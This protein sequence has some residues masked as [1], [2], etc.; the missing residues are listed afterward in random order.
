MVY[1]SAKQR[2]VYSSTLPGLIDCISVMVC[3]YCQWS[4]TQ[5]VLFEVLRTQ[6][7]GTLREKLLAMHYSNVRYARCGQA[8]LSCG[9][10]KI[11][12]FCLG[13]FVSQMYC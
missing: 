4:L 2:Q 10:R 11:K 3:R 1:F 8:A 7:S 12:L 9:Q 13:A 6:C 5:N